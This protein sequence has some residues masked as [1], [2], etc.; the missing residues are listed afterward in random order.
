MLQ[1][2]CIVGSMPA[3]ARRGADGASDAEGVE[4][5]QRG[6]SAAARVRDRRQQCPRARGRRTCRLSPT[7]RVLAEIAFKLTL[8][9]VALMRAGREQILQIPHDAKTWCLQYLQVF[10]S[11][12]NTGANTPT[13]E[14]R[15]G[16][17]HTTPSF[18]RAPR[19][20]QRA[21]AGLRRRARRARRSIRRASTSSC[22]R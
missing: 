14:R 18:A 6:Q 13:S 7:P 4:R 8:P 21:R 10:P 3:R 16:R 5:R 1:R 22:A 15:L 12:A 2:Y 9:W 11:L 19:W 17:G 20:R